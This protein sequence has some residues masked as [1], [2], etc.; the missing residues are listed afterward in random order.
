[1]KRHLSSKIGQKVFHYVLLTRLKQRNRSQPQTLLI[2]KSSVWSW[3]GIISAMYWD[4]SFAL[5]PVQGR[6]QKKNASCSEVQYK[7]PFCSP[8]NMCW[9]LPNHFSC[10]FVLVCFKTREWISA[11]LNHN[12]CNDFNRVMSIYSSRK[13]YPKS[14]PTVRSLLLLNRIFHIALC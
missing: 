13:S 4:T 7:A 9:M 10:Y 8:P 14:F 2:W 12:S 5:Q 11:L 3:L 6:A 1:M